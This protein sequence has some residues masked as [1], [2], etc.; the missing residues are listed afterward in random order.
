[1]N[2]ATQ[3]EVFSKIIFLKVDGVGHV[4]NRPSTGL[5]YHLEEKEGGKNQ[6]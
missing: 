2:K 1:M 3:N 4:D 6:M 5:L